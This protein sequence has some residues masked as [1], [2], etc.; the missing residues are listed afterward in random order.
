[1]KTQN[2]CVSLSIWQK[3]RDKRAIFVRLFY[4]FKGE[5]TQDVCVQTSSNEKENCFS[6]ERGNEKIPEWNP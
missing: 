2:L 1:M 4:M 5:G 6:S 3:S